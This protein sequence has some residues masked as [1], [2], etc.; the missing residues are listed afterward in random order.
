[1]RIRFPT[2][3]EKGAGEVCVRA[4]C[5]IAERL[6]G[7]QDAAFITEGD[8]ML[9]GTFSYVLQSIRADYPGVRWR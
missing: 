1:M 3:N 4:A 7:G 2:N 6:K 5:E 9:Y 8:P